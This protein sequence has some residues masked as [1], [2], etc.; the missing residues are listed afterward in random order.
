[1]TNRIR[2]ITLTAAT[3]LIAGAGVGAGHATADPGYGDGFPAGPRCERQAFVKAESASSQVV[4]CQNPGHAIDYTYKGLAKST[5]TTLV[6]PTARYASGGYHAF[7]N[8]YAYHVRP[9]ALE[10]LAPDGSVVSHEPWMYYDST[11]N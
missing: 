7:N 4:I 1:M 5:G 8:G 3:A 11:E 2:T 10:I 9:D 6:V